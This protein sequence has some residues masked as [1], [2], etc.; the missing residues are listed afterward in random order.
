MIFFQPE[1]INMGSGD[2]TRGNSGPRKCI[3]KRHSFAEDLRVF[4][5]SPCKYEIVSYCI[6]IYNEIKIRHVFNDLE[7]EL[8]GSTISNT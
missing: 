1:N 2:L 6:C 3:S 5:K 4:Q 8:V 7:R